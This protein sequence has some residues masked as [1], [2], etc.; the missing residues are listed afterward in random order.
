MLARQELLRNEEED[1]ATIIVR[2]GMLSLM[3][4]AASKE[5]GRLHNEKAN[6]GGGRQGKKGEGV[7]G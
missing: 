1:I 4:G 5:A 6:S 3:R 2:D 7:M